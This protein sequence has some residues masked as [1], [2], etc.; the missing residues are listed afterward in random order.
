MGD[1]MEKLHEIEGLDETS[2]EILK[3]PITENAGKMHELR[4]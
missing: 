3:F 2:K 4:N 1:L